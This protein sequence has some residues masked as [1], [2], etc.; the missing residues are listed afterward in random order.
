VTQVI[1]AADHW[2]SNAELIADCHRLGYIKDDDKVLDATYGRGVWWKQWRPDDL[3]AHAGDFMSLPYA[4]Q[5]FDVATFDPPYVSVGGRKTSTLDD[6]NDRYGLHHTPSGPTALQMV[7]NDGLSA[8]SAKVKPRG[9]VLVKCMDY[10]TSGKLW[11]GTHYTLTHALNFL[12]MEVVD[13][14]EHVGRPRPQPSGRRQVHARRNLST[15][16]VLRNP[17]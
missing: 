10:V 11:L 15:L 16:F 9:I 3:M 6:F 14:M 8:V 2:P 12:N 13:R 5:S 7:I 1:L 17:K 4:D